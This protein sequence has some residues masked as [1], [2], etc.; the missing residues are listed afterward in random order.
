MNSDQPGAAGCK[1]SPKAEAYITIK[2]STSKRKVPGAAMQPKLLRVAIVVSFTAL[3]VCSAVAPSFAQV[4]VQPNMNA[5]LQSL[6]QAQAFLQQTGDDKGPHRY[7]AIELIQQAMNEVRAGIDYANSH[8]GQ[9]PYQS[10]SWGNGRSRL[11]PEDQSRFDSYYSR[12]LEYRRTNNRDEVV[13]MERRMRDVMAHYNIP[14]D[15]PFEQVASN[16]GGG[17]YRNQWH[18]RLSDD[19]QRR[20]D[21]YYSRWLEYRRTNNR[22]EI[23]SMEKRMRDVMSHYN[24][25]SNTPF[26]QIATPR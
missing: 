22:D 15:V 20:F 5:A 6:Q 10:P 21:S 8:R 25:P 1:F 24:I 26:E 9:S 12:W 7:R 19:D 17:Y 11:S 18:S 4:E 13:S 3:L 14:A 23:V 2:T 16:G